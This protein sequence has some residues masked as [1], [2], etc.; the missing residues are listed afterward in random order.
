MTATFTTHLSRI[1]HRRR[2]TGSNHTRTTSTVMRQQDGNESGVGCLAMLL[3]YFGKARTL[4]QCRVACDAGRERITSEHLVDAARKL[5]VEADGWVVQGADAFDV[6]Q[7]PLPAIVYWQDCRFVVVERVARRHVTIVDPA[8]GRRRLARDVF[9]RLCSGVAVTLAGDAFRTPEALWMTGLLIVSTVALQ[10]CRLALPL[11][12]LLVV[13]HVVGGIESS[14]FWIGVATVLVVLSHTI[15]LFV[16]SQAVA[17]LGVIGEARWRH[18]SIVAC[19]DGWFVIFS[20]FLVAMWS[21]ALAALAGGFGLLQV[22]VVAWARRRVRSMVEAL[23]SGMTLCSLL[24]LLVLGAHEVLAGRLTV[25]VMLAL[26]V[27]AAGALIPLGEVTV[28]L[29]ASRGAGDVGEG[30][31]EREGWR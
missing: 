2:A 6:F 4:A 22:C 7:L 28:S 9:D 21:P 10:V 19:L 13:E 29:V 8:H 20:L 17:R 5:G 12:T 25:A 11:G 1:W 23:V 24:G 26:N 27:L 31:R 30:D 15:L 18:E 16:R 14:L 3:A